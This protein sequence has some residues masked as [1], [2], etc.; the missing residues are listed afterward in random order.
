MAPHESKIPFRFS[1]NQP[2]F[3][4]F[5]CLCI[6][7]ADGGGWMPGKDHDCATPH[8]VEYSTPEEPRTADAAVIL[9][10]VQVTTLVRQSDRG[11]SPTTLT[12]RKNRSFRA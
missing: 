11:D 4:F 8:L 9:M 10:H 2:N 7:V 3:S 1:T 12:V 5:W 6:A